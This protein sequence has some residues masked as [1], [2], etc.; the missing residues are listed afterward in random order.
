MPNDLVPLCLNINECL[1]FKNTAIPLHPQ[2]SCER[3]AEGVLYVRKKE[4]YFPF[5]GEEYG[6]NIIALCGKN[7]AGK[8]AIIRM[9]RSNRSELPTLSSYSILWV[10]REGCVFIS[11]RESNG[12]LGV[13]ADGN[14]YEERINLEG[15]ELTFSEDNSEL[16]SIKD[17]CADGLYLDTPLREEKILVHNYLRFRD[18]YD[19]EGVLFDKFQIRNDVGEYD[20]SYNGDSCA[21]G[22]QRFAELNS[23]DCMKYM[24]ENPCLAPILTMYT[25]TD[26]FSYVQE[27][28][29][30]RVEAEVFFKKFKTL[31][32]TDALNAIQAEYLAILNDKGQSNEYELTDYREMVS[33]IA[34]LTER[35]DRELNDILK[36][37]GGFEVGS[38]NEITCYYPFKKFDNGNNRFVSDLS[39]GERT[40]LRFIF[41]R[42]PSLIQKEAKWFSLD[43]P[44]NFMHP[45]WKR[46]LIYDLLMTY[47]VLKNGLSEIQ[48][49]EIIRTRKMTCIIATHSP[50]ILSDLTADNIVYL[51]REN[52]ELYSTVKTFNQRTFAGNI[53]EMYYSDFFMKET[54]GEYAKKKIEEALNQLGCTTTLTDIDT[55]E[56]LFSKVGDSILRNLL[57]EKI[58]DAKNRINA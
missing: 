57:M 46:R 6:L 42:T 19:A 51:E 54:I 33:S 52:E 1:C 44:D 22:W 43:E 5:V 13:S 29:T 32:M 24:M 41:R 45:E 50:F 34:S 8:S 36:D 53:G 25:D 48:R 3:D 9:L 38:L 55:F 2:Y 47:D 40:R 11:D 31:F 23:R 17:Y 56:R 26:L 37:F 28:I 58:Q 7:G 14:G 12:L 35:A 10:D 16:R 21:H 27:Q 39:D 15:A 18:I 4:D 49:E 30:E 20:Y